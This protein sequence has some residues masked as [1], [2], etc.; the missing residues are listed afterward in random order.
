MFRFDDKVVLVTGGSRGIGRGIAVSF[1]R[2]GARVFACGRNPP[3][4]PI[5]HAAGTAAEFI[6][7]DVR[8]PA[9]VQRLIETLL[10]RAGHLDVVIN[11]AG[12]GPQADAATA[13]PRFTEAIVRLN[14]LAP[15][16]VS[17]QAYPAL[18]EARG[19]IINIASVAGVRASPGTLAYGAAKAGL[20]SATASLA[21]EWGPDV[22]VN[23]IVAG[24][25]KTDA[26][27]EHY[28]GAAGIA[29]IEHK[30]PA[31]RMGTPADIADACLFLASEAAAYVSGAALEVHGGGEPPSFRVFVEDP[32]RPRRRG[33]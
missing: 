11:N 22:R 4:A 6:S 3:A 30:L 23:A 16:L 32:L 9:H 7:A 29:A 18:R 31:R 14:L 24:L 17:Q 33:P 28:G 5:A 19:V 25:V 20:L 21:Q 26:A 27:A 10:D 13:S 2:G 15:L 8:D 12:G 1:L